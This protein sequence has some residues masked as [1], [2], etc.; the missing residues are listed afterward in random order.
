M[1]TEE[2][3]EFFRKNTYLQNVLLNDLLNKHFPV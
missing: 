1:K 3:P 2:L